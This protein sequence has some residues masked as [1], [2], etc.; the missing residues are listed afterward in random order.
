MLAGGSVPGQRWANSA[1]SPILVTVRSGLLRCTHSDRS[2]TH[3]IAQVKHPVA[4]NHHVR[5][6]Q[7]VLRVDRPEV[8]LA[9][10]EH[11]G[12]DVHA[13]LIDQARGKLLAPDLANGDLDHVG[14]RK[15][16]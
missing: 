6:L 4:L 8:A 1:G 12:Y 13:H 15:P 14:T 9:G 3:P 7:Q 10:P 5:I 2:T 11:D 16:L